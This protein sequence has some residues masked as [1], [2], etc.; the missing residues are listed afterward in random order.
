MENN[1]DTPIAEIKI[2][3]LE[4]LDSTPIDHIYC[5]SD[6]HMFK[7]HY[8]KERNYVNVSD[9]VSWCKQNITNNDIFLYLGDL[10][11]RYANKED[12]QKAIEIYNTIPGIK[13]LVLGNHDKDLGEDFFANSGF[14]YVVEDI[15]WLSKQ[16]LFTHRPLNMTS[17][18][19]GY[20]N[21]H[22]HIHN[23]ETYNTT[24]GKLN[25][26]VYPYW[27]NNTC[28]TVKYLLD[29]KDKLVS[30]HSQNWCSMIGE[31]MSYG[32]VF[33]NS[34]SRCTRLLEYMANNYKPKVYFTSSITSSSIDRLVSK[35]KDKLHGDICLKSNVNESLIKG[36]IKSNNAE[37]VPTDDES[38]T[39][40]TTTESYDILRGISSYDSLVSI[41]QFKPNESNGYIGSLSNM[42]DLI[43]NT[44]NSSIENI[45]EGVHEISSYMNGNVIYVNIL[46]SHS[47]DTNDIGVLVSDNIVA[48]ETASI[49]F[50]KNSLQRKPNNNLIKKLYNNGGIYQLETLQSVFNTSSMYELYNADNDTIIVRESNKWKDVPKKDLGIPEDGKYPLDS[51]EHVRSAIKLFGHA[52][53][54][55]K[56][57]LAKRIRRAASKY[58][59]DIPKDCQV[60][61]YLDESMFLDGSIIPSD[62]DT[63]IF[64]LGGVLID[65]QRYDNPYYKSAIKSIPDL[66][67][68]MCNLYSEEFDK[69]NI[70]QARKLY[71]AKYPKEYKIFDTLVKVNVKSQDLFPYTKELLQQLKDRGYKLY[72][73]SNWNRFTH[74]ANKELFDKFLYLFDGG[75][76]SFQ[77][78]WMKPDK[79]IFLNLF[80]KYDIDQSKSLFI[81]DIE[82]NI[83]AAKGIGLRGI[84]FTEDV[85]DKLMGGPV[86]LNIGN[87]VTYRDYDT[88]SVY[89]DDI[90]NIGKYHIGISI[91]DY[92]GKYY[93]FDKAI[94]LYASNIAIGSVNSGY[95]F[96]YD[97]KAKP[98]CIAKIDISND[99][100]Y[101]YDIQYGIAKKDGIFIND[102]PIVNEWAMN[103]MNPI[104]GITKPF[105]LKTSMMGGGMDQYMFS[106]DIV[107]DKYLVIDENAN[108]KMVPSNEIDGDLCVEIYEF[109]GDKSKINKAYADISEA[110]YY[111]KS[112]DNTF[113]YTV[114]TGKPLLDSKQI[115]M[116]KDFKKIDL[117]E[118]MYQ[119]ISESV[120][121]RDGIYKCINKRPFGN[122]ISEQAK[123][124]M[125]AILNKYNKHGDLSIRE[126]MDGYYIISTFSG[127]RTVS[128]S[129]TRLFK[130]SMIKPIL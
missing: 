14:D 80:Y 85:V 70:T 46:E 92:I 51:E 53:E 11:Y 43:A 56:A 105:I 103:A 125:V 30:N 55:K 36:I 29:H 76:F 4:L 127:K 31:N 38:F 28:P 73:L 42:S 108:L 96:M 47:S 17:Y 121:L 20:L 81:D 58:D 115:D 101:S 93:K 79:R 59:I 26:N 23:I 71:K 109:I 60:A 78:P 34:F 86:L 75:V 118:I 129:S 88:D 49:D 7:S 98:I 15:D 37:I 32:E 65:Y 114:L 52:E 48:V 83:E 35:F 2:P 91:D 124:D 63:L 107:N 24:D 12:Q 1:I 111:K 3:L 89:T 126:D 67:D 19:E 116:D 45:C 90:D 100:Q 87:R 44:S 21:I 77:T 50:I 104:V 112:V 57:S 40:N 69:L 8:K 128:V 106:P 72:Y 97:G 82:E 64:D 33:N 66:H 16:I 123:G 94:K 5:T 68:K 25:I 120:T 61:K 18:P 22:G 117:E 99:G 110:Y 27:Y 39:L 130:E 95:V 41:S 6:W 84:L 54:D 74:D 119:F 113:F 10:V 102:P 62:V 122:F 13:V 9:I